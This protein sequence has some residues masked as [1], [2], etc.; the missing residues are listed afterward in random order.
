LGKVNEISHAKFLLN[1][2]K[3]LRASEARS[4]KGA[5]ALADRREGRIEA[6]RGETLQA[7]RCEARKP[8]PA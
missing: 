7:A 2:W 3:L 1:S 4:A 6:R 8:D 5:E